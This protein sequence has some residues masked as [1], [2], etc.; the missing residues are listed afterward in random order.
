MACNVEVE[1]APAIVANDEE[2]VKHAESDGRHREQVH[3]CD[4]LAVIAQEGEPALGGIGGP[5]SPPHPAGDAALGDLKAEHGEF[6]VDARSAPS[7][8]VC[9]HFE[10]QLADLSGHRLSAHRLTRPGD[11]PPIQ[12]KTGTMPAQDRVG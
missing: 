11:D 9:H 4:G 8:I 2:A 7:G 10:D 3:G 12:L 5:R 6:A 1:N